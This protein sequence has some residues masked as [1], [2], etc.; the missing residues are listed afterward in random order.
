MAISIP[1]AFIQFILFALVLVYLK[2]R[3]RSPVSWRAQRLTQ[4]LKPLLNNGDA[5]VKGAIQRELDQLAFCLLARFNVYAPLRGLLIEIN[6]REPS[7]A[8]WRALRDWH[9]FIEVSNGLLKFKPE[10]RKYY[11]A[12]WIGYRVASVVALTSVVLMGFAVIPFTDETLHAR[13]VGVAVSFF[14]LLLSTLGL[15]I[16]RSPH[17]FERLQELFERLER[18]RTAA[19][20]LPTT[21]EAMAA[22]DVDVTGAKPAAKRSRKK[23]G[24]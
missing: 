20:S 8:A 2:P 22:I 11:W 17:A 6:K 13:A 1:N 7:V 23:N 16:A 21:L 18:E 3:L 10:V 12:S 24:P 4:S 15:V 14:Y 19:T 5:D 9:S